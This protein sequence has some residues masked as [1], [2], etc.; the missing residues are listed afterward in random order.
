MPL[1]N[2]FVRCQP[3]EHSCKSEVLRQVLLLCFTNVPSELLFLLVM[4]LSDGNKRYLQG[5][6]A[7]GLRQEALRCAV[8]VVSTFG[9]MMSQHVPALLLQC[10]SL[11]KQSLDPYVQCIV[12]EEGDLGEIEVSSAL[13]C[14][15]DMLSILSERLLALNGKVVLLIANSDLWMLP[16]C[17]DQA[18]LLKAFFQQGCMGMLA[19]NHLPL[20]E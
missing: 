2:N 17:S 11:F 13:I 15:R 6:N 9:K 7:W 4:N 1:H 19:C 5:E 14:P 8:L 12:L 10:W 20:L 3:I 16:A 18:F